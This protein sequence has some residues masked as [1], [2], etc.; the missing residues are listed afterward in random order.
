MMYLARFSQLLSSSCL[1][2]VS[3]VSPVV[4]GDDDLAGWD[5]DVPVVLTPTRLKQSEFDAPASVSVITA[6]TIRYL[7]IKSIPEALRYASGMIVDYASGNSPR[8]NYHGT[9]GL[10]PRRMQVLLDGISLYRT[11]YA[12]VSW[13]TLPVA[14]NDIQYIEVIRSPSSSAFGQNSMMAVINIVTKAAESTEPPSLSYGFSNNEERHQQG[15]FSGPLNDNVNYMVSV[16]SKYSTGYDENYRGE[17]RR[18]GTDMNYLRS[19]LNMRLS[20]QTNASW[21][22]AY[23]KGEHQHEYRDSRQT[24]FP[25]VQAEDQYYQ[26]NI[27]HAF[28]NNHELKIK[29]HYSHAEQIK[30]WG[31]CN[32]AVS[33]LESMTALDQVNPELAGSIIATVADG[34]SYAA[35]FSSDDPLLDQ[36]VAD[37]AALGDK[38]DDDVCGVSNENGS[39]TKWDVEVEDT[40]S[41]NESVRLVF[42]M[43]YQSQSM[44]SESMLNGTVSTESYRVFGNSE[45]K[46]GN[47]TTN[48]GIMAEEEQ[49]LNRVEYSPRIGVNYYLSHD[50]VVRYSL[51]KAV[52]TPDILETHR[53][54][55]YE[56]VDPST[57]VLGNEELY[58]YK[59]AF[60]D[61]ELSSE[62][63]ISNELGLVGRINQGQYNL[64]YD[65]KLFYDR[66]SNLIS[67]KM[68]YMNY[69][70]SNGSNSTLKG[71]DLELD[72]TFRLRGYFKQ[73]SLHGRYSYVDAVTNHFY[74]RSL[75]ADHS[76]ALFGILRTVRNEFVSLSYYG[77]SPIN[78]EAFDGYEFGGGKQFIIDGHGIEFSAKGIY[79]PDLNHKLTVNERFNVENNSRSPWTFYLTTRIDI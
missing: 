51:S 64:E 54:W 7:Q 26:A 2:A 4:S 29:S 12:Q 65:A 16:S 9:N 13:P 40:I 17:E 20:D 23:S 48:V 46:S 35:P 30:E 6:D 56:L 37:I 25:D 14:M 18:D 45:W 66:L 68:T 58:F 41:L 76:G 67:E 33:F 8:V 63:I 38:A 52:R 70:A 74:E 49:H 27:S 21:F 11:G 73:A 71:L 59:H 28:N 15:S 77:N 60:F 53:D 36:V 78:G 24:S 47:W 1:V 50:A 39:E 32:P 55:Q 72:I 31:F 69:Q 43:G 79:Y 5:E 3:V 34:N 19:K 10:V 57:D 22:G 62:E 42:G 44:T 61:G 75:H